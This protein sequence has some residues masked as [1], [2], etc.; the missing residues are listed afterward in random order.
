MAAGKPFVASDVEGIREITKGFG[1]L[2]P[3]EDAD[4]LAEAIK[5]LHDDKMYYKQIADKC[6]KRATQFDMSNMVSRYNDV[7]L[8]FSRL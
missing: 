1:I 7:Y 6:Y 3:H 2:V 8:S 5:Q 4:A